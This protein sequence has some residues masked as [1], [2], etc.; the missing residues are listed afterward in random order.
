[1][2]ITAGVIG[3]AA[4]QTLQDAGRAA[5]PRRWRHVWSVSGADARSVISVMS[6]RG[7]K[8]RITMRLFTA[9]LAA[10]AVGVLLVL[11]VPATAATSLNYHATFVE[12]GG[13]L[14]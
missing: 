1:M 7:Q 13:G 9:A 10:A 5:R 3:V 12:V 11:A 2:L 8:G 14:P 4:P 6:G